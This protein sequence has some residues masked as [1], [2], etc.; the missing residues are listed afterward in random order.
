MTEKCINTLFIVICI[1]EAILLVDVGTYTWV[2]GV[3]VTIEKTFFILLP[4]F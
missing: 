1:K 4:T 3:A 2:F